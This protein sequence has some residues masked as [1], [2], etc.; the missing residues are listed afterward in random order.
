MTA[1]VVDARMYLSEASLKSVVSFHLTS[2]W[3][4]TQ[5]LYI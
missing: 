1:F 2:S 4:A 5:T 3:S